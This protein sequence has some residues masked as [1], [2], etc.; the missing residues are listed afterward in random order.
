[1]RILLLNW[2][3]ITH[4]ASGGAEVWA[5]RLAEGLVEKG[6]TVTFFTASVSGRP[7]GEVKNG[8]QL[9]RSGN[10]ITVYSRARKYLH[11]NSDQFDV[12]I[13]EINTRPFFAWRWSSIP[14]ISMIHQT[15]AEVW[16][17]EAPFPLS[18]IGRYILE[19][20]W[21]RKYRDRKVM[22]LSPSSAVSLREIGIIDV[23]VVLPGSDEQEIVFIAKETRPTVCF[24]ARMVSS[25][26]PGDAMAAFEILKKKFPDAQM[27]FMGDGELL[28]DLKSRASHG[29]YFLGH[30]SDEER[31]LRLGRAH[32]LVATSVR[33]GW[34]L[35]VSEAAIRGTPTIGYDAPGLS[36]SIPMSGGLV[37]HPDPESLARALLSFFS[38]ELNLVPKIATQSW[39]AVTSAFDEE[40]RKVTKK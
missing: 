14:V 34:G 40:I 37:T 36:D 20:Y 19:P 11:S 29:V 26:R 2:R 12:I 27:W 16:G 39:D 38:G 9:V 18:V 10:R 30:V 23:N 22:T 6:H 28:A 3:D 1:M 7:S 35:N 15:A 21:L 8:V 13:E 33:E 32:V 24:L 4:P 31:T 5:H 25:K 17:H